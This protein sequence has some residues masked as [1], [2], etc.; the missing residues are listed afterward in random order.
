MDVQHTHTHTHMQADTHTHTITKLYI[1]KNVR[2]RSS[3]TK[4]WEHQNDGC[5][6]WSFSRVLF[7]LWLTTREVSTAEAGSIL[8]RETWYHSHLPLTKAQ[9]MLCSCCV[10]FSLEQ[11][12]PRSLKGFVYPVSMI[13]NVLSALRAGYNSVSEILSVINTVH[14]WLVVFCLWLVTMHSG[15]PLRYPDLIMGLL[16]YIKGTSKKPQIC[17]CTLPHSHFWTHFSSATLQC[18]PRPPHPYAHMHT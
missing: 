12:F 1:F 17:R 18:L 13:S 3:C 14:N 5:I 10:P 6:S 2:K 7:L 11:Q 16:R 15:A 9:G 8:A 4:F